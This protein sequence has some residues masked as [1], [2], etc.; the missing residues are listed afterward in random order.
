MK[1][2][3]DGLLVLICAIM[4]SYSLIDG[5]LFIALIYF[6][7]GFL[8]YMQLERGVFKDGK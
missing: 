4:G 8:F 1:R 3:V 2:I 5:R 6:I 7:V